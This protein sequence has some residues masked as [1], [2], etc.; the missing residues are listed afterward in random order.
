MKGNQFGPVFVNPFLADNLN[1][2]TLRGYPSYTYFSR[3]GAVAALDFRFPLGRIFEGWGTNPAFLDQFYGFSFA[4]ISTLSFANLNYLFP[5]VGGG[6]RLTTELLF[7]PITL[8]TEY[9]AGLRKDLR[10]ADDLFFQ[11]IVNPLKF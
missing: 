4:E 9:H 6:L 10:G 11:M 1:Q 3:A 2:L 8:S 7:I 5:C